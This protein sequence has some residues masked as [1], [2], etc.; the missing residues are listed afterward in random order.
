[1][2]STLLKTE[3]VGKNKADA[4]T[5]LSKNLQSYWCNQHEPHKVVIIILIIYIERLADA[6][7]QGIKLYKSLT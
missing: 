4:P 7:M 3:D 6:L 5:L 2:L 1:M